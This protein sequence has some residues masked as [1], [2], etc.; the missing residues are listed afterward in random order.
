MTESESVAL[1]FGDSPMCFSKLFT[2]LRHVVLYINTHIKV[3]PL[4][5]NFL[6]NLFNSC[7]ALIL[8]EKIRISRVFSLCISRRIWYNQA[9]YM[10]AAHIFCATQTKRKRSSRFPLYGRST[11]ILRYANRAQAK[12]AVPVIWA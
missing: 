11:Y 7:K 12:F 8:L 2:R 10:G 6:K 4:F 9:K 3:N 1:P 5:S